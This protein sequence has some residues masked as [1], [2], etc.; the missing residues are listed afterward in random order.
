MGA[1]STPL[2]LSLGFY[3]DGEHVFPDLP[4]DGMYSN[5]D[6]PVTQTNIKFYAN[7]VL[8]NVKERATWFQTPYVLWP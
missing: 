8:K 3:W 7:N 1:P 5:I 6:A 2:C 4:S